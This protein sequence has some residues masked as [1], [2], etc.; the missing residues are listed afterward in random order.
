MLVAVEGQV[1]EAMLIELG[2]LALMAA[3]VLWVLMEQ[4]KLHQHLIVFIEEVTQTFYLHLVSYLPAKVILLVAVLEAG[5]S[6]LACKHLHLH[7]DFLR[8][9][10]TVAFWL[11]VAVVVLTMLLMQK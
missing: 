7:Q 6:F 5:G 2:V 4:A 11:A 10:T 1:R 9:G 8:V 3:V